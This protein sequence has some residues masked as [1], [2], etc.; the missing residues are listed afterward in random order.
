M[1][2]II[3]IFQI[4]ILLSVSL[5]CDGAAVGESCSESETCIGSN[6]LCE[7]NTCACA[8]NY[9]LDGSECKGMPFS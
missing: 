5:Y 3:H 6:V 1:M 8:V 2:C 4:L 9:V 7:S